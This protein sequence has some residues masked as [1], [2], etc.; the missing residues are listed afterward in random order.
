[1]QMSQERLAQWAFRLERLQALKVR[2]ASA[3][4]YDR[5]HKAHLAVQRLYERWA[6]EVFTA[7][8]V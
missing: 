7:A 2:F 8:R 4:R 3:N 6:D 1:M 5:A